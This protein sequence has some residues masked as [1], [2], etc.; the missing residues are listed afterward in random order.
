MSLI[1]SSQL[2]ATRKKRKERDDNLKKQSENT[3]KRKVEPEIIAE[4]PLLEEEVLESAEIAEVPS[5]AAEE[6]ESMT[7]DDSFAYQHQRPVSNL[8]RNAIPEF[9]PAEYLEDTEPS[10]L[11]LHEPM[12]TERSISKKTKFRDL[13]E[14]QP[15]D[16]RVGSTTYRVSKKQSS[17]LAPKSAYQARSIK[18]AWLQGRASTNGGANRKPF[19]SGFFRK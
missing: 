2:S 16:K 4:V 11:E 10:S 3:K 1:F 19:S 7:L 12:V 13:V 6:E 14:K 9:L 18:E 8:Y 15:K 5:E 17:N